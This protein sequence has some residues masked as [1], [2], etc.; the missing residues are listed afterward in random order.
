[1]W[2]CENGRR[3]WLSVSAVGLTFVEVH[4]SKK[5]TRKTVKYETRLGNSLPIYPNASCRRARTAAAAAAAAAV[6][7]AVA[8]AGTHVHTLL[9]SAICCCCA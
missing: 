8:A 3:G 9:Y 5:T 4:C 2:L 6:A 1:M 7:G